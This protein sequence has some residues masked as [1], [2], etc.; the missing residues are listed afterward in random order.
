MALTSENLKHV[1][2]EGDALAIYR[3][4]Q[5]SGDFMRTV[6]GMEIDYYK[7]SVKSLRKRILSGK[8]R[9]RK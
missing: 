4:V 1:Y 7:P 8:Y 3:D 6:E 5:K 2:G 9:K